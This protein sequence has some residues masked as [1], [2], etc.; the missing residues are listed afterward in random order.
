MAMVKSYS[1]SW[2]GYKGRQE[3]SHHVSRILGIDLN[4]VTNDEKRLLSRIVGKTNSNRNFPIM[5]IFLPSQQRYVLYWVIM[6]VIP[7]P[8]F[9]EA[10]KKPQSWR[11]IKMSSFLALTTMGYTTERREKHLWKQCR[12]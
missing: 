6:E 7:Y 1:S 3:L 4:V 10:L 5:N 11:V 2:V 9:R 8:L 12:W